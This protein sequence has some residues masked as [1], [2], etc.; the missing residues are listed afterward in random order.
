MELKL[1]GSGGGSGYGWECLLMW[2]W[3]GS[4]PRLA[5]DLIWPQEGPRVLWTLFS[6]EGSLVL[7]DYLTGDP[8]TQSWPLGTSHCLSAMESQASC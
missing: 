1:V 8:L 6:S 3:V 4:S 7:S 5:L 2:P